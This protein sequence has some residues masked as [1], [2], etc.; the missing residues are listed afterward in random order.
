[1]NKAREE[2][3]RIKGYTERGAPLPTDYQK[4][5]NNSQMESTTTATK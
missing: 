1:M 5:S 2:R 4:V 3:E